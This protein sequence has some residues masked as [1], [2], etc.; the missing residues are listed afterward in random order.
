MGI[1]NKS[2]A[3]KTRYTHLLFTTVA[4]EEVQHG[5][6]PLSAHIQDVAGLCADATL[7]SRPPHADVRPETAP[8]NP[9]ANCTQHRNKPR[10][11]HGDRR[12][13]RR[14]Y[15]IA[16]RTCLLDHDDVFVPLALRHSEQLDLQGIVRDTQERTDQPRQSQR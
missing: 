12:G 16:T 7:L 4:L 1:N 8:H 10:E 15:S 13:V 6:L 14:V 3:M 9:P 11:G 2:D 5:A